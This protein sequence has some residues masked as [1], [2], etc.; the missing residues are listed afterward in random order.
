MVSD[1]NQPLSW[2]YVVGYFVV[3]LVAY[4]IVR[5]Q[6]RRSYDWKASDRNFWLPMLLVFGP[7]SL[8]IAFIAVIQW[9]PKGEA[10]RI[11]KQRHTKKER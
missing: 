11:I 9:T 4:F 7:F 1:P 5:E 10:D 2:W 6:W 8:F 3:G